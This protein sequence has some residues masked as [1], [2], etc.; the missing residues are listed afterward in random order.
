MKNVCV[1]G[2]GAI[3]PVHAKALEIVDNA[4]LYG[5]CDINQDRLNKSLKDYPD[6]KLYS[7][8]D[9]MLHDENI[10]AVH[11]CAPHYL[12]YEMIKKALAAE[13]AIIA[14]KPAVMTK[15]EFKKLQ[16]L[17]GIENVCFVLQNR[18][19]PCV[20]YLKDLIQGGSMGKIK[21]IRGTLFWN[22]TKEYY[23]SDAW[24]GKWATEGGGVLI[25]QA[26]HTLDL[27]RYFAGN[28]KSV[29][30]NM[31]N[32]SLQ[33][34]IEVED[35]FSAYAE[36]ENG[37]NGVFFATNAYAANV[38]P[39]IEVIFDKGS[40]CYIYGNILLNGKF[41]CSDSKPVDNRKEYWG[42]GHEMLIKNFY[43]N[44]LYFNINDIKNSMETV[45]AMYES[46]KASG[47]KI[48]V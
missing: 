48:F 35:T 41:V 39:E 9:E 13:K 16:A 24:R 26:I 21:A 20:K 34:V 4:A 8:F 10:D 30:A 11:I 42:S 36:F 46:A 37:I 43:D 47:T 45:F 29:S 28:I 40:A 18:L 32:Y 44:H 38:D 17:N 33:N 27:M 23:M 3:G 25:N 6:I 14:E 15:E 12:H 2:D 5:I 22:R 19:N 1:V 7:D 31:Y